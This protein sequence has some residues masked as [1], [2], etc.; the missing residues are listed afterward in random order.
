MQQLI[1]RQRED[2]PIEVSMN[3]S[4]VL[5]SELNLLGRRRR[6]GG[7]PAKGGVGHPGAKSDRSYAN[8]RLTLVTDAI[9]IPKNRTAL[10]EFEE[11]KEEVA[12]AKLRKDLA[13]A[14]QM[15]QIIALLAT[16]DATLSS[17]LAVADRGTN[18][19]R[20][21]PASSSTNASPDLSAKS[22]EGQRFR[23]R[24]R[25]LR[26]M[27]L[28]FHPTILCRDQI[29]VVRDPSFQKSIGRMTARKP[30]VIALFDVD[31]T[32][33][34]PRKVVS[35]GVVGGSDLVKITEQLGKTGLLNL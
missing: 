17:A 22:H 34:A 23:A 15:D 10:K 5:V 25:S 28:L 2:G 3:A 4:L 13:E 33:T 31:G 18:S 20:S 24:A 35:V 7:N 29:V 30:D 6:G 8:G 21:H 1:R 27:R 32:L 26:G 9:G 19:S 11:F 14:I 12:E 16:A